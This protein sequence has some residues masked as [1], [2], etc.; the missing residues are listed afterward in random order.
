MP[1]SFIGQIVNLLIEN[2]FHNVEQNCRDFFIQP[3]ESN[4]K[5]PL[6]LHQST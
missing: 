1:Y 5:I 6:S 2:A 4:G 3:E